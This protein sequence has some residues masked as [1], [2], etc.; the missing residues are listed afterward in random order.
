MHLLE[1]TRAH[2]P[3]KDKFLVYVQRF[4]VCGENAASQLLILKRAKRANGQ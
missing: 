1:R 2:W 3:W 4:D